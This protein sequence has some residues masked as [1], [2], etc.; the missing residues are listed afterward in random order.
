MT[1]PRPETDRTDKARTGIV[2]LDDVMAGGFV[3]DR[4][5]LIEGSPGTG[6]TTMALQFLL[7]GG[8]AGERG[9][10][11]TLSET[12]EEL[13]AGAASHGWS[14]E[15][16]DVFELAP[17]ENLLDADQQQS[18]LYSSDLELGETTKLIIE[19]IERAKPSRIILDSLSELRLLAQGSL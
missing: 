17:P 2:G 3:R 4:L 16:I 18:L 1:P 11:V 5:Y 13:R 8:R 7:D 14:L 19:A 12:E 15:N 6:K 9:L 10:Y